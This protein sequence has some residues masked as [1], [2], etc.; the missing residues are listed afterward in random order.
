M[1]TFLIE[2]DS[3]VDFPRIKRNIIDIIQL[4]VNSIIFLFNK[5]GIMAKV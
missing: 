4:E 1:V 3:I 2:N 5:D